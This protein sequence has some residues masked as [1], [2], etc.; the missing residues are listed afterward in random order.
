MSTCWRSQS[1]TDEDLLLGH[2]TNITQ[3]GVQVSPAVTF[4]I[5]P[6]V[7]VAVHVFTLI[8]YDML[9][10]NLRQFHAT[11]KVMVPLAADRERCR[12][13]LANVEFVVAFAVP[14]ESPLYSRLFG[15]VTRGMLAVF[16]VAVLLA[17]QV[18]ALRYQEQVIIWAQRIALL[19][20]LFVLECHSTCCVQADRTV[21]AALV[22]GKRW[23]S[24]RGN[25]R[26]FTSG[27]YTL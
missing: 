16:P 25:F 26:I 27:K 14:Q 23:C 11:L 10:T 8:R 21:W 6:L 19:T 3:L 17:V 15:N 18:S 13:L 1:T 7:F 12:Q 20:D 9:G 22:V 2:T 24:C 4:A 5:A